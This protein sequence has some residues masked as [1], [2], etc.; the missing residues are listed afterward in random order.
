M[1]VGELQEMYE[2]EQSRKNVALK[3]YHNGYNVGYKAGKLD[4]E[5]IQRQEHEA[6]ESEP[7][8]IWKFTTTGLASAIAGLIAGLVL[9]GL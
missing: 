2:S 3:S 8:R 9:S 5:E 4:Q 6:A 7:G 1:S